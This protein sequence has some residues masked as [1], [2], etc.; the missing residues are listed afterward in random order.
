MLQIKQAVRKPFPINFEQVTLENIDEVAE[1][2]KGTVEMREQRMLGTVI[3]LPVI[4]LK[5]QGDQRNRVF[6]ATL[7]CYIAEMKGSFRVYKPAQFESSFDVVPDTDSMLKLAEDAVFAVTGK[8][9]EDSVEEAAQTAEALGL[10]E[11]MTSDG[12]PFKTSGA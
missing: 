10:L 12:M 9:L 6:D 3:K 7:G 2:C 8:T 5:G 1:W 4:K 11:P